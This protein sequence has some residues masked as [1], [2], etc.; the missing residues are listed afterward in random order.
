M[1]TTPNFRAVEDQKDESP[2]MSFIGMND[3]TNTTN[4]SL[5]EH[6]IWGWH[7]G[8]K[9]KITFIQGPSDESQLNRMTADN[10]TRYDDD[11]I[12]IWN[13]TYIN[14]G[15]N[16]LLLPDGRIIVDRTK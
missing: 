10:D 15:K 8:Y 6:D 1:I 2:V 11:N 12:T 16:W 7:E 5:G 3:T 13:T 9:P 14:L 4:T